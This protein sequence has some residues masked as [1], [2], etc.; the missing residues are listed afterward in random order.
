MLKTKRQ[1]IEDLLY[2]LDQAF[3]WEKSKEGFLFWSAIYH[4]IQQKNEKK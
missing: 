1:K 3:S 2:A 4:I